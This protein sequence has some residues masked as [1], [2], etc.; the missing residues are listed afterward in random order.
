MSF[1]V[2]DIT[3]ETIYQNK[4]K[5]IAGKAWILFE[6]DVTEKLMTISEITIYGKRNGQERKNFVCLISNKSRKHFSKQAFCLMKLNEIAPQDTQMHMEVMPWGHKSF[7]RLRLSWF[8]E[9][10]FFST[11][12]PY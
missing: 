10:D 6:P 4:N 2:I 5:K 7:V 11:S 9:R 12:L 1:K 3:M 8:R